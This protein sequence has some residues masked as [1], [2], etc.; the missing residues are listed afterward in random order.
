[1]KYLIFSFITFIFIT[2]GYAVEKKA[3]ISF[4]NTYLESIHYKDQKTLKNITSEKFYHLLSKH[5]L[6]N[7]KIKQSGKFKRGGFDLT[8]KPTKIKGEYLLNI[9]DQSKK[10]YSHGWYLIKETKQKMIIKKMVHIE[11]N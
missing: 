3:L 9:K 8:F 4:M 11:E 7:K 5:Y 6:E 2:N 1:M 10:E